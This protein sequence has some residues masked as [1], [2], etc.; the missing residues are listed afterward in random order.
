MSECIAGAK[1]ILGGEHSVVTRGRALAFP[2]PSAK[3][4]IK[5]QP[6]SE[7][8]F[9]RKL[10]VNGVERSSE[11]LSMIQNLCLRVGADFPP[12]HIE[13][14]SQIP[15]GAGLGSSAALCVALAKLFHPGAPK[16]KIAEFALSGE[17]LFHKKPS[18]IDPFTIAIDEPIIFSS[19]NLDFRVLNTEAFKKSDLCFALFDTGQTHKT[20]EVQA[21]VER[22]KTQ[23]PLIYEDLMDALSSNVEQ[24]LRA[25]ESGNGRVLGQLMKDSHFRLIQLGVSNDQINEL[26][27]KIQAIDS[28]L[29]VKITGA[30]CG[31]FLLGLFRKE[32]LKDESASS[33]I[34]SLKPSFFWS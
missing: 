2:L 1:F 6:E 19:N 29:G 9:Q 13:I 32:A 26:A 5:I 18:G 14:E 8:H 12:S 27:Q 16:N 10:I 20:M 7:N 17:E 24:M 34:S 30:G 4:K 31:G 33:S 22:T 11:E 21:N 23:N 3:I 28:C 15:I 25:F